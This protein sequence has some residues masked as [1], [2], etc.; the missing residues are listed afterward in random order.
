[1]S[2]LIGVMPRPAQE[3]EEHPPSGISEHTQG[4]LL[5]HVHL[6][7]SYTITSPIIYFSVSQKSGTCWNVKLYC[8]KSTALKTR[9]KNFH[10]WLG[11]S[12]FS[13]TLC[14]PTHTHTKD[15]MHLASWR[16]DTGQRN[17]V[18]QVIVF[19]SPNQISKHLVDALAHFW[20]STYSRYLGSEINILTSTGQTDTKS[21]TNHRV[22]HR[23]NWKNYNPDTKSSYSLSLSNDLL[24][25]T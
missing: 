6:F 11:G 25:T 22:H 13:L 23:I 4:K 20:F 10:I 8:N 1:M 17:R 24:M 14:T 9:C 12:Y 5:K 21:G 7:D 19:H 2:A 18:Q 3:P 16:S 15:D